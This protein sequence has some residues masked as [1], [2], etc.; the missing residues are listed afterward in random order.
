[1][2]LDSFNKPLKVDRVFTAKRNGIERI[3]IVDGGGGF[4][5]KI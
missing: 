5:Q 1:M 4:M 2:W 3:L